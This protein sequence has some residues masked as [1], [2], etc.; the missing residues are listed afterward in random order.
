MLGQ[1]QLHTV[2]AAMDYVESLNL[3]ADEKT[4]Q[5]I[6]RKFDASVSGET[7][8]REGPLSEGQGGKHIT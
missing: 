1:K 8:L 3:V 7:S 5:K 4:V 6:R 2:A